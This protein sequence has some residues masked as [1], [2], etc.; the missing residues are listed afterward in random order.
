MWRHL[1]AALLAACLT[2]S[3]GAADGAADFPSKPIRIVVPFGAG[4]AG[5]H[6]PSW[7][8]SIVSS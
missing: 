6:P 5:D 4:G 3:A 8:S 1:L 2:P 7:T